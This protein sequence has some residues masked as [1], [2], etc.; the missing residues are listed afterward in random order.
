MLVKGIRDGRHH[1]PG[2]GNP[3]HEYCIF[4][5]SDQREVRGQMTGPVGCLA[6]LSWRRGQERGGVHDISFIGS[7]KGHAVPPGLA[8]LP[9]RCEVLS[10]QLQLWRIQQCSQQTKQSCQVGTL[11]N[12]CQQCQ[13]FTRYAVYFKQTRF[14]LIYLGF[15]E[16]SSVM[17]SSQKQNLGL[18]KPLLRQRHRQLQCQCCFLK[19]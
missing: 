9:F 18:Q 2:I 15:V 4:I 8:G 19:T 14:R 16:A 7:Y 13:T 12:P 10:S 1:I 5:G 6:Q 17:S 3:G 11:A